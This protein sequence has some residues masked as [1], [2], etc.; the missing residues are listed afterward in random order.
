MKAG[1]IIRLP[2]GREG[3]VVYHGLGGYGIQWGRIRV[4]VEDIEEA[5]Q[6]ANTLF[7]NAPDDFPY[8]AEA[9]LREPY[10]G[11]DIECVGERYKIVESP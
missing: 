11:A 4:T 8:H 3:T 7:G 9:M 6:G 10:S 5:M 2:D 1:T